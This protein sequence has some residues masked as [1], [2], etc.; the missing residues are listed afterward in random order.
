MKPTDSEIFEFSQK[1]QEL[2]QEH[3]YTL[4]ESLIHYQEYTGLE[5]DTM[6]SLINPAMKARLEREAIEANLIKANTTKLPI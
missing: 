2:A 1:I 6:T 5:S 4:L 3:D